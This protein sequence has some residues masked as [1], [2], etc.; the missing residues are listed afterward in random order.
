MADTL[1]PPPPAHSLSSLN[2][3]SGTSSPPR[4]SPVLPKLSYSLRDHKK[5]I[6]L[7]WTLLALDVAIMPLALFYPLWYATSLEPAYIFA[8]TTGVFGIISGMEWVFRSRQLWK[9]EDVELIVGAAPHNPFIRLC[10]MPAPS[11]ILFFGGEILLFSIFSA[12]K[13]PNPFKISSQP[14]GAPVRPG[15]YMV[16]EDVIA[17]DTGA[18]RAYRRAINDRYEASPMFRRMLWQLNMFW[19]VPALAV[20]VGVTA[21][22]ADDR[23]PQTIAYG[24]GWG[25]PP[26]W[27]GIW[28]LITIQWVQVSLRREKEAWSKEGRV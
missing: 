15:T 23:V 7:I 6:A 19:A 5:N 17:V 20:G 9:K 21:V 4:L 26:L 1:N 25:A 14:K 18:G 11:F 28:T 12:L 2:N 3:A 13:I 16:I 22:V 10:A 8:I 24:I 27:V